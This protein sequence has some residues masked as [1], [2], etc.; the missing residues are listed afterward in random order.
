MLA[1]RLKRDITERGRSVDGVLEQYLRYVK[2]SYDVF[3][4]PTSKYADIVSLPP[5]SMFLK[6]SVNSQSSFLLIY[7]SILTDCPWS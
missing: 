6:S 2:P 4:Q 7:S 5:D 3:V 1:R